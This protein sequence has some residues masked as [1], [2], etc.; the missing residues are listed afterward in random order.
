MGGERKQNLLVLT[1]ILG[2][3]IQNK[4]FTTVL[5]VNY[6]FSLLFAVLL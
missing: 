2:C 1:Y 3:G 5:L 6:I 4:P